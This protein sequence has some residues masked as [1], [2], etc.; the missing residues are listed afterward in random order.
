M[1]RVGHLRVNRKVQHNGFVIQEVL[2]LGAASAN[3]AEEKPLLYTFD[4]VRTCVE[5]SPQESPRDIRSSLAAWQTIRDLRVTSS[6][7]S[8]GY[9]YSFLPKRTD[10]LVRDACCRGCVC[11]RQQGHHPQRDLTSVL[12]M[13][14]TCEA[15]ARDMRSRGTRHA[16]HRHTTCEAQMFR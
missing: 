5:L 14:A 11:P 6:H 7:H 8:G 10:L 1:L 9:C 3:Q 16:K 12:G 2:F 4:D 13:H 15:Q